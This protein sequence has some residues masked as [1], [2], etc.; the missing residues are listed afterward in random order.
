MKTADL[1]VVTMLNLWF[2]FDSRVQGVPIGVTVSLREGTALSA[3]L[4]CN[5][6]KNHIDTN[7]YAFSRQLALVLSRAW[8]SG[9]YNDQNV[10]QA[11]SGLGVAGA[12]SGRYTVNYS[13][14]LMKHFGLAQIADASGWDLS[15]AE[16]KEVGKLFCSALN[17]ENIRRCGGRALWALE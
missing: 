15:A 5:T 2:F 3:V 8:F 12:C 9:R 7:C 16:L 13:I 11:L 4:T 6:Q 1:S 14:D 17:E 10:Y